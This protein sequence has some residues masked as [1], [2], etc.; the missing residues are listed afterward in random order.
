M[1]DASETVEEKPGICQSEMCRK[2]SSAVDSQAFEYVAGFLILLNM[3]LIGLEAEMQLQGMDT[4]WASNIERGFLTLYSLELLVRLVAGGL[5]IFKSPWHLLDLLLVSVGLLALVLVPLLEQGGRDDWERLLIIRGLRLLRLARVLR[6]LQHFKVVWRLVSG[7]LSAWDTLA[8]TMGLILLWL[9]IFGCVAIEVI[10]ND[11]VLLENTLTAAIIEK[12]FS[13]SQNSQ[14]FFP[15]KAFSFS[16]LLR[17]V[18]P[19]QVPLNMEKPW[20]GERFQCGWFVRL[21]TWPQKLFC[22][23]RPPE[24]F[25]VELRS[26]FVHFQRDF[27]YKAARS[28][29]QPVNS[30]YV[31]VSCTPVPLDSTLSD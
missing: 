2:L 9:Y 8:S 26:L 28:I 12:N 4:A 6:T 19:F 22:A 5:S 16:D 24:D 31:D 3:A 20:P 21:G 27:A 17:S 18:G 14:C 25:F 13:P 23:K 10:S 1:D 7:L 30:L 15:H 11:Q 29:S